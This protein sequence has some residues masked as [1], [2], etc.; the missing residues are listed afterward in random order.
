M[1]TPEELQQSIDAVDPELARIR[2]TVARLSEESR[3]VGAEKVPDRTRV[4]ELSTEMAALDEDFRHVRQTLD[5]LSEIA[6][7]LKGSTNVDPAIVYAEAV[8]SRVAV[9]RQLPDDPHTPAAWRAEMAAL[10]DGHSFYWS[11][12]MVSVVKVSAS[13]LPAATVVEP[14]LFPTRAGWWWFGRENAQLATKG[15]YFPYHRIAAIAWMRRDDS[16]LWVAAFSA[17]WPHDL[18]KQVVASHKPGMLHTVWQADLELDRTVNDISM[19]IETVHA[20]PK[21]AADAFALLR[22]LVAGSLF[23]KQR[24]LVTRSE[25]IGRGARKRIQ[26]YTQ[27]AG[28][29]IV[30]LRRGETLRGH[31][32]ERISPTEFTCQWWVRGHWRQQ[33]YKDGVRPKWIDPYIKGD[34]DKPLKAPSE[35]VFAVVR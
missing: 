35:K 1:M 30:Q 16:R 34:P 8:E 18:A 17:D 13:A 20:I 5:M 7:S 19:Y 25:S 12:S 23:I 22:F 6:H 14:T 27:E 3:R 26:Q 33:P 31:V 11:P 4:G 24:V 10:V 2:D 9:A 29:E 15:R 28:I 21:D 32:T